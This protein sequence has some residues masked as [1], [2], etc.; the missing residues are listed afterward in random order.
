MITLIAT[1]LSLGFSASTSCTTVCLPVLLPYL[2]SD[3]NTGFLRGLNTILLFTLGRMIAYMLLG[4]VVVF[5]IGSA[6][7]SPWLVPAVTLLLGLVLFS[8]GLHTL[9]AFQLSTKPVVRACEAVSSRRPPFVMGLLVG[10]RPCMPLVAALLYSISLAGIGQVIIFMF[11]FGLASSLLVVVLGLAGRGVINL[12]VNKV[13][14]DRI[15]RLSGLVL[16]F[17]GLIF[18]IQGIGGALIM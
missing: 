17:L 10:S 5:L 14:L 16:V 6:D 3:K 13:G 2:A 8:Y 18:V 1:G 4:I 12:L 9:G 15:R 7:I 11:F